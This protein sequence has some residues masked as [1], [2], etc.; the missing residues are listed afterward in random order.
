MSGRVY[1][2]WDGL[3]QANIFKSDWGFG[4][5]RFAG[6]EVAGTGIVRFLN[7][8]SRINRLSIA[9]SI[10]FFDIDTCQASRVE[11]YLSRSTNT[12]NQ[13]SP[14]RQIFLVKTAFCDRDFR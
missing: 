5:R 6:V 14:A 11:R 2:I 9:M 8:D 1:Y 12:V 7:D 13:T 4:R 3:S 10:D